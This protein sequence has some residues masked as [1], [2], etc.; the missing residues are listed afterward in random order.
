MV[1]GG[2]SPAKMHVFVFFFCSKNVLGDNKFASFL[3]CQIITLGQNATI[4]VTNS[5]TIPGYSSYSIVKMWP[6]SKR[7]N[8]FEQKINDG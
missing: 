4:T 7:L 2:G 5:R 1:Q 3:C 6:A 8:L